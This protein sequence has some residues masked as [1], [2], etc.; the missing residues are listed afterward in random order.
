LTLLLPIYA[1]ATFE[2]RSSIEVSRSAA[3]YH[4]KSKALEHFNRQ[5]DDELNKESIQWAEIL[6]ILW[7]CENF[8]E[9]ENREWLRMMNEAEWFI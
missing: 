1:I 2:R 8:F 6:K 4:S 7:Q 3:L 9:N 5:L